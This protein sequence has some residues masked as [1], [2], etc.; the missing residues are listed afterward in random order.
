MTRTP[1]PHSWE[2]PGIEV[3]PSPVGGSGL[4]ART[5]ITTGTTVARLGGRLVSDAELRAL[6]DDAVRHPE[7]PYVDTIAVADTSH[8]VLP[9]RSEQSIGYS[10]H[11]CDPNLW[12]DGPYTLVARRD[13][14]PDEELT[15]DYAT[16]TWDPRFVLACACGARNGCRGTV[17]GSDWRLP[18]LQE[19]YGD[20]WVP[21]V[22][23][24]IAEASRS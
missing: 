3:R 2:H 15:S 8:L 14:A 10:N 18:E 23:D 4:L 5:P 20:H 21:A 24:R 9:P 7:R 16:N 17:T 11:S 19:R 1:A 22:L 6:L 13:I 12:W